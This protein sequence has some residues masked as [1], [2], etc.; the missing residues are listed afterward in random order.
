MPVCSHLD[1]ISVVHLPEE[2]E[3]CEECL[4]MGSTWVHLRMC[5]TCGRIGC[6][7]SSPNKHA[8]RHAREVGHPIVRSAQPGEDWSWCFVDEIAF[9]VE[10]SGTDPSTFEG[11]AKP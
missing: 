9:V 3:G 8:S 7:D 1:Q 2:I 11:D 4:R 5:M 6:C 10:P